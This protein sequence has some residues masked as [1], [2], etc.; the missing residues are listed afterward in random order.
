MCVKVSADFSRD[1]ESRRDRQSDPRH[2]GE[3]RAFPAEQCFHLAVA[4]GFAIAE[5]VDVFRCSFARGAL[6]L[7]VELRRVTGS[8]APR[9][10]SSSFR[11][12][13]EPAN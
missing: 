5:V 8:R 13:S 3:V 7:S 9:G 2:L 12:E 6:P 11:H 1:R 10:I 4:V